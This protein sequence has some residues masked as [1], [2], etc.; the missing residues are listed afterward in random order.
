ML[1]VVP[2]ATFT[3]V[4]APPPKVTLPVAVRSLVV[5]LFTL[6]SRAKATLKPRPV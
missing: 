2:V 4:P 6:I 1:T 5:T 3:L